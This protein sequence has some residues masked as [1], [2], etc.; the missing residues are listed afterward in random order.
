MLSQFTV[1]L[2]LLAT[3]VPTSLAAF[4]ERVTG[5]SHCSTSI[6][7]AATSKGNDVEYVL[8]PANN[9]RAEWVALGFGP[10]MVG[11]DMVILWPN[12][13]G[14]ITLSQR[15]AAAYSEPRVVQ[16]PP[17]VAFV[18]S[19]MSSTSGAKPQYAFTIPVISATK[20]PR[21]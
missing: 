6:C 5:D 10:S 18:S 20:F 9:I 8:T 15:Y 16:S 1:S 19:D 12:Q 14:S 2:L 17:R 3:Q 13:D 4:E 21:S 11:S 7:V